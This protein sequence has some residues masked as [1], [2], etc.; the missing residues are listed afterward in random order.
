MMSTEGSARENYSA[1][2]QAAV[3][4]LAGGCGNR[5]LLRQLA[6]LLSQ[7]QA[8]QL[9]ELSVGAAALAFGRTPA[10]LLSQMLALN[11]SFPN[12]PVAAVLAL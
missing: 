2:L 8:S 6:L 9:P 11:E 12:E 5:E 7:D 3:F 10:D 1:I 4:V